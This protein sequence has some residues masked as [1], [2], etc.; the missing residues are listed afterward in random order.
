MIELGSAGVE[1]VNFFVQLLQAVYQ[2]SQRDLTVKVPVTEDVIGPVADAL[3]L[4]TTET[5]TVLQ[6]VSDISHDVAATSDRVKEQS[7]SVIEAAT[8]V[9]KEVEKTATEL[10]VTSESML[11][12]SIARPLGQIA[13][14]VQKVS[15]G[16]FEARTLVDG[17]DELG[18]LG[19]TFDAMLNDRVGTLA[20]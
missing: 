10:A 11:H 7:D 2:L 5:A 3:N 8:A 13:S 18:A 6:G 9:Q 15:Q 12:R 4:L 20:I 14:A 17:P 16:N 1:F 19:N